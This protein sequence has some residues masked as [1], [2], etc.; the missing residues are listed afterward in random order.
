M[1]IEH[2]C[3]M[4]YITTPTQDSRQREPLPEVSPA[5]T[6]H[7]AL[8]AAKGVPS[9]YTPWRRTGTAAYET[10]VSQSSPHMVTLRACCMALSTFFHSTLLTL[11][12]NHSFGS[13]ADSSFSRRFAEHQHVR[14]RLL[15][16]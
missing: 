1:Y 14:L 4:L 11:G 7:R 13:L 2:N 10:C 8:G 3:Y 5:A 9:A 16:V 6:P 12:F 15:D